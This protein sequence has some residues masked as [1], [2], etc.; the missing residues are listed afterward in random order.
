MSVSFRKA[1]YLVALLAAAGVGRAQ[2]VPAAAPSTA[3]A[4]PGASPAYGMPIT[5]IQAEKVLNAAK[6]EAVRLKSVGNAIAVVDTHGELVAF[7]R[8]DEATFHSVGYAQIKARG[9][10][11]LRRAGA[12]PPAEMA[13]VLTAMPDFVSMP[14]GIPIVV[15]GKTI[16]AIGV[17]GGNDLAIAKAAVAVLQ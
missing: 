2:Q 17:S 5:L 4:D 16:G 10:A 13:A 14:G 3:S 9:A 8:M 6:S 1:I 15:D 11:R 12:T 7:E